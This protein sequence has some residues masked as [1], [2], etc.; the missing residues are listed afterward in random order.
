MRELSAL[1]FESILMSARWT[2]ALAAIA[3]IGGSLGVWR[4]RW[5]GR[6]AAAGSSTRRAHSSSCSRARLC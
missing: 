6:R 2:L 3:L 4:S 5:P 1:D